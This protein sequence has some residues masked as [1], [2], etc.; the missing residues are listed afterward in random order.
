MLNFFYIKRWAVDPC[1]MYKKIYFLVNL[2]LGMFR[3]FQLEANEDLSPN[4][5]FLSHVFIHAFSYFSIKFYLYKKFK[6][7]IKDYMLLINTFRCIIIFLRIMIL[8][9]QGHQTRILSAGMAWNRYGLSCIKVLCGNEC[10]ANS[11]DGQ[12]V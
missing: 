5:Y 6:L 4:M 1:L 12:V 3:P 10:L 11:Y 2:S 8:S 9:F 7:S